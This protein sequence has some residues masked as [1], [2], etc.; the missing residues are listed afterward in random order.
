M[1]RASKGQSP[2]QGA[3]CGIWR[4]VTLT[5]GCWPGSRRRP[6]RPAARMP[7]QRRYAVFVA[8]GAGQSHKALGHAERRLGVFFDALESS[9]ACRGSML[10]RCISSSVR[11]DAL[12][13]RMSCEMKCRAWSRCCSARR[14]SVMSGDEPA[15]V[16]KLG[17]GLAQHEQAAPC[18]SRPSLW[19]EPALP[20]SLSGL[21]SGL[22]GLGILQVVQH[23][24][25]GFALHCADCGSKGPTHMALGSGIGRR[26][27][28]CASQT[29]LGAGSCC[30]LLLTNWCRSR[31]WR[32]RLPRVDALF[33]SRR[34]VAHGLLRTGRPSLHQM[35]HFRAQNGR[36]R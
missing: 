31:S 2:R 4:I 18:A 27:R 5:S 34:A 10:L 3:E 7:G 24:E 11:M 21:N 30:R 28:P 1:A 16:S 6:R 33:G 13:A 23:L 29:K 14:I 15:H 19:A 9:S 12:G 26:M 25:D 22:Q 8:L 17:E 36:Q 20:K 35:F 32:G